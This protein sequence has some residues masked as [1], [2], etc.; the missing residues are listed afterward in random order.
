ML[1]EKLAKK[2]TLLSGVIFLV[3]VLALAQLVISYNLATQ[4]EKVR[5]LELEILELKQENFLLTEKISRA[6]SLSRITQ[7][8]KKL[9]MVRATQ[10]LSLTPQVPVALETANLR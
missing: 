10:V 9:G 4:G 8:A 2:P 7:E 6:G 5:Q 3:V 1:K